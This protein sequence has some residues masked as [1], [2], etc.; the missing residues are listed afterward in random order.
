MAVLV[1]GATGNIG[2]HVVRGL[3]ERGAA[4]RV[5]TRDAGRA[6][7]MLPDGVEIVAGDIGDPAHIVSA[8]TDV[9]SVF[10]LTPHAADMA[11]IQLRI[12][13]SLRRVSAR[14]VKLSGTASA[15]T[16]NGPLTCREHW[17]IE[18]IL[19]ASGQPYTILRPN[20]FMQVLIDQIMIPALRVQ[21]AIPNAIADSGISLIDVRDIADAAVAALTDNG[22]EGRTLTLT[23]PRS[24]TYPDI[25]RLIGS[26]VGVTIDT[27]DITP[28]VVRA[29]LLE[30]GMQPWE[31]EHFEEMYQLF[32]DGR[33][34][35][36]SD[37]VRQVT[38]REPRTI[39]DYLAERKTMLTEALHPEVASR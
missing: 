5:L 14:I 9:E 6:R 22:W 23:G 10:L 30:R 20:A 27:N 17:E 39:E 38:G 1:L 12:I 28:A 36:V 16:P 33:S 25:A 3:V 35:F 2:P 24:V 31:A 26:Q 37:D 19:T 11:D 4:V 21:G 13:R 8:A 15:I 32:R 7:A 18:Q 29:G 34:E